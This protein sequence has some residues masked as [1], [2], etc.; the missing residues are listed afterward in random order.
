MSKSVIILDTPKTCNECKG[1]VQIDEHSLPV[2]V[3]ANRIKFYPERPNWCPLKD[4][5]EV[6]NEQANKIL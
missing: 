1:L 2:C 3:Y 6:L 5:N 4:L